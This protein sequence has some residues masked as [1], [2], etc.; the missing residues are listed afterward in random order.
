MTA[1]P[2]KGSPDRTPSTD[3]P[4]PSTD[5]RAR[6]VEVIEVSPRDGLQNEAVLVGT[7]D[8][9]ALIRH[10]VAAGAREI[11]VAAFVHPDR[12]PAMADAEAV[13]AGLP[14][15]D[16]RYSAL[17]LNRRGLDRAIDA[18]ITEINAVVVCSDTFGQR[19]QGAGIDRS[20][21]VWHELAERG[22]GAGIRCAVTLAVAFGC[23]FEGEI[24]EDTVVRIVDA[25]LDS[26]PADLSLAD[27]IG[28][29]VPRQVSDLVATLTPLVAERAPETSLRAHFHDTR[30]TGIA[31][32]VAAVDA[33]V[34]RLD[35][36]LGGVGGC[37]FAPGATGNVGTED[38]AYVFERSGLSTGLDLDALIVAA[39][40]LAEVVGHPAAA[41]LS[42]AGRFPL[43]G[44]W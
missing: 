12:V 39:R 19:N 3:A 30:N 1:V 16:V 23:P 29:A 4:T 36:S 34:R 14:E 13:I 15:A 17:V 21:D 22:R 27:T 28:V 44:A 33:G 8:K 9:L 10:L 31:N 43:A 38:L 7:A 25:V 32:A 18:G 20:I 40:E 41:M 35:A 6:D 2:K 5:A 24:S 26:P 42:R 37:P 11:E